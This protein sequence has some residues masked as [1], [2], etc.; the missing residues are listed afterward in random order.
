M[1]LIYQAD[2]NNNQAQTHVLIVG[3]GRYI[4]LNGG[5]SPI[6]NTMGMGQLQSPPTSARAFANWIETKYNNLISPLGS[7]ELLISDNTSQVYTNRDR[8]ELS[9]ESATLNNVRDAFRNWADRCNSNLNNVAIFYFCGHGIEK[10]NLALLLEDFGEYD[11]NLFENAIN[12]QANRL[13]MFT[14][15][16]A[17]TQLYFIDACRNRG[18]NATARIDG[19]LGTTFTRGETN[20]DCENRLTIMASD[21]GSAA[22][23]RSTGTTLFTEALIQCLDKWGC[24]FYEEDELYAN[25][26]ESILGEQ[27]RNG[28]W[29]IDI[30]YLFHSVEKTLKR[31]IREDLRIQNSEA[32]SQRCNY[33]MPPKGSTI[34]HLRTD[35]IEIPI[36]IDVRPHHAR[37]QASLSLENTNYSYRQKPNPA[38]WKKVICAELYTLIANF[39]LKEYQYFSKRC[40]FRSRLYEQPKRKKINAIKM[41]DN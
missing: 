39:E 6:D 27:Y 37:T 17:E 11:G 29:V 33:D 13:G 15:C 12:F 20:K 7:V 36:S 41:E 22:Y 35:P 8:K 26:D 18:D 38:I 4:H 14:H 31:L 3:V 9:I 34:I 28:G 2:N 32:S 25:I 21:S 23:G 19:E 40:N 10:N 24:D 1:T 5:S 30:Q 16:K